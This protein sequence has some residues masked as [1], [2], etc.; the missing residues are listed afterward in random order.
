VPNPGPA[1]AARGPASYHDG[2]LYIATVD[3]VYALNPKTGALVGK[4]HV[5]GRFGIVSP[6]IVGGTMYLGNS[7]DWLIA[8]PL[9]EVNPDYR[10]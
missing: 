1:G 10:S 7:W 9:S 8:L 5:G 6:T 4:K 3:T 2:M